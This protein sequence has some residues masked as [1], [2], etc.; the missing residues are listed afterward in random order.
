MFAPRIFEESDQS[1]S[2]ADRSMFESRNADDMTNN[3][4]SP[5][6][7][8]RRSHTVS[9]SPSRTTYGSRWGDNSR[10]KVVAGTRYFSGDKSVELNAQSSAKRSGISG[11]ANNE[12]I[13]ATRREILQSLERSP[14]KLYPDQHT[15]SQFPTEE[16]R[17]LSKNRK[18]ATSENKENGGQFVVPAAAAPAEDDDLT[19]FSKYDIRNIS[20]QSVSRASPKRPQDSNK[21]IGNIGLRSRSKQPLPTD[22]SQRHH[23]ADNEDRREPG[24]LFERRTFSEEHHNAEDEREYARSQQ[25]VR[26]ADNILESTDRRQV[27]N[28]SREEV[29]DPTPEIAS[30]RDHEPV[31]SNF[32]REEVLQQENDFSRKPTREPIRQTIREPIHEPIREPVREQLHDFGRELTREPIRDPIREQENASGRELTREPV[33]KPVREPVRESIRES[34]PESVRDLTRNRRFEVDGEVSYRVDTQVRSD[35]QARGY[36]Q[37]LLHESAGTSVREH[38][39]ESSEREQLTREPVRNLGQDQQRENPR[40]Y[41]QDA[42]PRQQTRNDYQSGTSYRARDRRQS[43]YTDRANQTVNHDSTYHARSAQ[44]GLSPNATGTSRKEPNMGNMTISGIPSPKKIKQP[45]LA[46]SKSQSRIRGPPSPTKG[47]YDPETNPPAL[48]KRSVS[49]DR[50]KRQSI[51]ILPP[52]RE[53]ERELDRDRERE[54]ANRRQSVVPRMVGT[55]TTAG[56]TTNYHPTTATTTATSGTTTNRQMAFGRTPGRLLA[57]KS[58]AELRANINAG[59]NNNA[60]GS[61]TKTASGVSGTTNNHNSTQAQ[62]KTNSTSQTQQKNKDEISILEV[63]STKPSEQSSQQLRIEME[64]KL[65]QHRTEIVSLKAR[66]SG[67]DSEI[68]SL[69]ASVEQ[70]ELTIESEARQ[71]EEMVARVAKELHVQYNKKHEAKLAQFKQSVKIKEETLTSE[72]H[73]LR[74]EV[75]NL[76]TR[77]AVER[78]EKAELVNAFE[79][80]QV[81]LE[82]MGIRLG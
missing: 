69:K 17:S 60:G 59:I 76:K 37:E 67:K 58:T 64:R 12:T 56:S 39:E 18:L 28:R 53:R 44:T 35:S 62:T 46:R 13:E 63:D 79:A 61:G 23:F 8:L 27:R 32:L 15:D 71:R 77:I 42:P 43:M 41:E 29:G 34:V 9:G 51:A 2:V 10:K 55:T 20:Y 70:S 75:E 30:Y 50:K 26:E 54:R 40:M 11:G 78:D 19:N 72:I 73:M 14:L 49:D 31:H 25:S 52:E 7:G 45:V 81:E 80:Y 6:S 66:L 5:A 48:K 65:A 82:R 47:P 38:T 57:P 4:A 33:H 3:N 16:T 36:R 22:D 74:A 1:I 21:S 24:E 68:K